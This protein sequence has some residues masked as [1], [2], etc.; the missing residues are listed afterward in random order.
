MP[1]QRQLDVLDA[2]RHH[3]LGGRV[4]EAEADPAAYRRAVA[5][6]VEAVDQHPAGA[7]ASTSP[8]T[9][10]ARVD[11]P[12]PLAPMTRDPLLGERQGGRLQHD[13]VAGGR[14]RR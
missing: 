4:G 5:R 2:G 6:D 7:S 12:E 3:Q 14:A 8:L 1:A 9:I 11:L 10:R 13:P